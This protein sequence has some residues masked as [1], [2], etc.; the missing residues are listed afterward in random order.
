[1][2]THEPI[3]DDACSSDVAALR[4]ELP[5]IQA[6]GVLGEARLRSLFDYLAAK[7]LAG[8]SPKEIT[9]AMDVFGKTPDFDV[10][11]DALVRVYIHKLRKALEGFYASDAAE[12][13]AVL[14]IPR[15]EYRL[16][17]KSSASI[18]LRPNSWVKDHRLQLLSAAAVGM[19]ILLGIGIALVWPSQTELQRVRANPIWSGMLNDDRPIVIVLGDYYLI[20][21]TDESMEVKRLVREYSVNSKADLDRY[22]SEHPEYASR[23]MDVGLR[24]LPISA[25]LALRNVMVVLAP[26]NRRI[27]V[28][29][30]SDLEPGSLKSADIVY[31]GYLSGMGMFQDLVFSGSRFAVGESYDEVI[32][33]KT[34][35]TYVSQVGS[36]AVE[37]A[38]PT[39]K[40]QSYHDYGVFEK[41][42]GPG[43]NTIIVVAGTRDEGVSQTAEAFTS[44]Q[45]LNEL[46]RQNDLT[47]PLEALI[48]VSAF[49][50]TNLAG[51]LLVQS[52][53][54]KSTKQ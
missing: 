28:S 11:Q 51:N 30:M 18:A 37:P 15:G 46:G 42:Q 25:A 49:N 9:I 12:G 19:V 35:H 31:I 38:P 24:Y 44:L 14:Y 3:L 52:N 26:Q 43:G 27:T 33:K 5:R 17:V 47:L 16:R 4:Q 23:Y 8:E 29:K 53:R 22:V 7:T 2:Q 1:M 48:E 10:S 54:N 21:E 32:D 45:K 20:G 34:H 39:G 36:Q 6:S 50:G 13:A 41:L 40:E